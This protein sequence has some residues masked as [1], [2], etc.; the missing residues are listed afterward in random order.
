MASAKNGPMVRDAVDAAEA[1]DITVGPREPAGRV[2][3][4][5]LSEASAPTAPPSH[6]AQDTPAQDDPL[7]LA[8]KC[9][10]PRQPSK[11]QV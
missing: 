11:A 1:L 4:A 9:H 6:M 3:P 5:E 7:A 2:S 8:V 10:R